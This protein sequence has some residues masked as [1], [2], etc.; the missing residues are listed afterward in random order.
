MRATRVWG[1][2]GAAVTAIPIAIATFTWIYRGF[3]GMIEHEDVFTYE[4]ICF[5][6]FCALLAATVGVAPGAAAAVLLAGA[7]RKQI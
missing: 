3:A 2:V 1:A 4:A 5:S 7:W 6:G